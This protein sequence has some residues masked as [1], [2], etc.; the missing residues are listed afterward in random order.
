M[1][2]NET[3]M[4]TWNLL[5]ELLLSDRSEMTI[6]QYRSQGRL[7]ARITA[8]IDSINHYERPVWMS[9][10]IHDNNISIGSLYRSDD[11]TTVHRIKAAVLFS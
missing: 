11:V 2:L 9:V 5:L 7:Q 4:R 3:N 1:Q 8:S 10:E 6:A